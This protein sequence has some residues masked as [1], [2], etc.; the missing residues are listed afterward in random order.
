MTNNIDSCIKILNKFSVKT[1]AANDESLS[2]E[3]RAADDT[4]DNDNLIADDSIFIAKVIDC[5]GDF[6]N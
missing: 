3:A 4:Q 1:D 2:L 5:I 6:E